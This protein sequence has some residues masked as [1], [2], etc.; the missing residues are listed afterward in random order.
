MGIWVEVEAVLGSVEHILR[1][2]IEGS[3]LTL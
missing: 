3:V 2:G 1:L